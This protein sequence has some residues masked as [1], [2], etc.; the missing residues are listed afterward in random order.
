MDK[1]YSPFL[2]INWRGGWPLAALNMALKAL[3]LASTVHSANVA[4][5][6]RG[7]Q[8]RFTWRA[9][10]LARATLAEWTVDAR[11]SAFSAMF[12]TAM[13]QPPSQSMD[14]NRL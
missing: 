1:G 7:A 8:D 10:R 9:P 14:R 3:S 2:S 13:G 5:G 11:D 12:K 4:R 6:S